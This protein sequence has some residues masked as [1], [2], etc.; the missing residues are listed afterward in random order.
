MRSLEGTDSER[1][2]GK[3]V[4]RGWGEVGALVGAESGL[5]RLKSPRDRQW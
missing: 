1:Q 4:A 3:L 5:E 2:N